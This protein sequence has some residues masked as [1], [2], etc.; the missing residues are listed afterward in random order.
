MIVKKRRLFFSA[1]FGSIEQFRQ[2]LSIERQ[3]GIVLVVVFAVAFALKDKTPSPTPAN[4]EPLHV[5]LSAEVLFKDG[6]FLV[7]NG[8][9]FDWKNITLEINSGIFS[10]GHSLQ[11]DL[12]TPKKVYYFQPL[13]FTQSDGKRFN[14][15]EYKPQNITITCDTPNGRG[16][17]FGKF[18]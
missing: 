14:P 7:W 3:V 18:K 11:V 8:G 15:F 5:D 17:Y 1:L 2:R 13:E 10:G 4:P 12:I 6:K 9:S 16:F